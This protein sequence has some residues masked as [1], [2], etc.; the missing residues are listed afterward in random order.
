MNH[1]AAFWATVKRTLPEMD[2]G[3]S[4]LK[5]HGRQLMAYGG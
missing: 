5:T 1:S 2:K 3:R 4:W